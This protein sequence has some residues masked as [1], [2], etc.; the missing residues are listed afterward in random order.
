MQAILALKIEGALIS[1]KHLPSKCL[2][3][4]AIDK[5]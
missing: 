2:I 3:I 4:L 5:N 1:K